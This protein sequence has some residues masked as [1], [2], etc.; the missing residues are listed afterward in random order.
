MIWESGFWKEELQRQAEALKLRRRQ[1]RWPQASFAKV[2]LCLM[3][4]FFSIRRLLE[5]RKLSD[6][7]ASANFNVTKIPARGKAVH[8]FNWHHLE[9]LY[10]FSA[11][12]ETRI[13]LRD[14]CNHFVHS[15]V[16]QLAF[17]EQGL[18]RVFVTCEFKRRS[19][20][21]VVGIDQIIRLFEKVGQDYP[22]EL[23]G[24]YDPRQGEW[25]NR[26]SRAPGRRAAQ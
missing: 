15:Y 7:T 24:K 16:F 17:D 26:Q 9:G 3:H 20:L 22:S 6:E 5:S 10:D 8:H 11:A 4:G 2:E 23:D 19:H 25:M 18:D 14:L 21:Y 1:K 12:S 13:G